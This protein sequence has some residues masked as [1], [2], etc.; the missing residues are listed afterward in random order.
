MDHLINDRAD[1]AAAI[2]VTW[3]LACAIALL[4]GRQ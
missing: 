4:A 2:L 3:L 1:L